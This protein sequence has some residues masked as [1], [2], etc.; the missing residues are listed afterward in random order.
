MYNSFLDTEIDLN[1]DNQPSSVT[2]DISTTNLTTKQTMPT[3]IDNK[4]V[5][6]PAKENISMDNTKTVENDKET[7]MEKMRK[8]IDTMALP[9]LVDAPKLNDVIAFKVNGSFK[10]KFFCL[11]QFFFFG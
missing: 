8:N 10:F 4:T 9:A 7:A 2:E 11:I 5:D 6:E 1:T 3:E